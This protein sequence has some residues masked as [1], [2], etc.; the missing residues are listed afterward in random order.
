MNDADRVRSTDDRADRAPRWPTPARSRPSPTAHPRERRPAPR[1]GTPSRPAF[2]GRTPRKIEAVRAGVVVGTGLVVALGAAVAHG[3]VADSAAPTATEVRRRPA[4]AGHRPGGGRGSS[5]DPGQF[6]G[7]RPFGGSRPGVIGPAGPRSAGRADR[8]SR[9]RADHVTA[10]SGSSVS[11]ATDDG[12]TRTIT[13]TG[14]TKI[15]KG[16]A[17]ATLADIAVGDTIRFG[18][19]RNADGTYTITA[20]EIVR[21]RSPGP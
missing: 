21:P 1:P 7:L 2:S 15:T 18:Q 19:T 16:G 12:W 8:R 11:L 20:I 13:V 17:A 14:T 5:A 4:P 9:L 10:V 6:G 3:R